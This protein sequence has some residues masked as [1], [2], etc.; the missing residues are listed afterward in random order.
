MS[1]VVAHAL[2]NRHYQT[3]DYLFTGLIIRLNSYTQSS[4]ILYSVW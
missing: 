4:Y 1:G 2:P 3:V